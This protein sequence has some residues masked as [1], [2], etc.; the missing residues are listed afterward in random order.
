MTESA[1]VVACEG[2]KCVVRINRRSACEKC[3]MCAFPDKAPHLDLTLDNPVGASEG[4]WVEV[5]MSGNR[6]LLSSVVVYLIPLFLAGIGL[7][8]GTLF[9]KKIIFQLLCCLTGVAIGYIIV[10]IIDR[11]I[12]NRKDFVPVI[13]K[14]ILTE[15]DENGKDHPSEG[16]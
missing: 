14:I 9:F 3:R 2:E 13:T 7:W 5:D 11:K 10:V 4:D 15:S 12:K 6:V 1:Q 16:E 8:L